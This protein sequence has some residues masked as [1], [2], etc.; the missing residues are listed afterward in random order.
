MSRICGMPG[1]CTKLT[2]D[3]ELDCLER[4]DEGTHRFCRSCQRAVD[5]KLGRFGQMGTR[6]LAAIS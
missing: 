1:S 6:R 5:R 3:T 2:A 4:L